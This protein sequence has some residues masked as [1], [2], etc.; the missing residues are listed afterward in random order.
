M[1]TPRRASRGKGAD[2]A[3]QRIPISPVILDGRLRGR[4]WR[5]GG[6]NGPA[7]DAH[8]DAEGAGQNSLSAFEQI[9]DA[10]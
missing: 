8:I 2:P 7:E 9:E 5:E 1:A 3:I 4:P 6:S 10:Q